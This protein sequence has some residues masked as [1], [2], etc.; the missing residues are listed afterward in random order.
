MNGMELIELIEKFTRILNIVE[1]VSLELDD[2]KDLTV[3]QFYYLDVISRLRHPTVSSL[4]E[5]IGVS[6][7]TVTIAL[8]SLLSQGY[9]KKIQS[10][11]DKRV[12]MIQL[13]N[14]GEK[15][16][17]AHDNGHKIIV[18]KLFQ[19]LTIDELNQ[20]KAILQKLILSLEDMPTIKNRM[21]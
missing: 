14:R 13:T 21:F 10:E 4:S 16:C 5:Q 3:R 9:V 17:Q 20:F 2:L 8:N 7:P 6:K 11:I 1:E 18:E 19:S 15:V 12:F